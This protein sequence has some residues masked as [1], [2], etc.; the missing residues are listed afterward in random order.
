MTTQDQPENHAPATETIWRVIPPAKDPVV[1]EGDAACFAYVLKNQ[2]FSVDY[3]IRWG[4]WRIQHSTD[5]G[6]TWT[7]IDYPRSPI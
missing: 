4:G 2:P 7:P 3:A 6:S 5:S 1:L